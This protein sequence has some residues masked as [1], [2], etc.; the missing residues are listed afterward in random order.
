M[1][2]LPRPRLVAIRSTCQ[3]AHRA[4]VDAHAAL[5]AVQM[6]EVVRREL[7]RHIR[8]DNR[9]RAAIF[10]RQRED[11]HPFAARPHAAVAQDAAWPVE[12]HH[13]RPLLLFAMVLRLGVKAVRCAIL[14]SHVLQLA[15][16]A[17][18]A[19]RAVQRMVAQQQLQRGLARL[20]H[21]R[22]VGEED[23]P[24]GDLRG[25]CG[26]ELRDFLLAHDAHAARSLQ[27]EAGIVAE[28]RDLYA[29]ALADLNQ[30]RARGCGDLLAVYGNGYISH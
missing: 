30:Q 21:L 16:A 5:L 13:G 9:R 27:A 26:L 29:R 1:V 22:R 3:R 20:D 23:L 19:H 24:L 8:H 2:H 17:C 14:E 10:H 7:R 12:V 25:A 15:L 11:I 28:C 6:R 4:H 18:I